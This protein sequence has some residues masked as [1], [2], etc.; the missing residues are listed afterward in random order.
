MLVSFVSFFA[1]CILLNL[2]WGDKITVRSVGLI[3]FFGLI[4]SYFLMKLIEKYLPGD[5]GETKNTE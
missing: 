5:N 4:L 1:T 2:A 3:T